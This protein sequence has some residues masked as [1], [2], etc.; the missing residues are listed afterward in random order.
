[1]DVS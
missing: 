1:V